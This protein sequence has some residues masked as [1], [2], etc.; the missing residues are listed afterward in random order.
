MPKKPARPCKVRMCPNLVHGRGQY[1][2]E[3]ADL[4]IRKDTRPSARLRGYDKEWYRIR[5]A[6][7]QA[8]PYCEEE[9]C[10]RLAEQ[11]D[12]KVPL[13]AGGTNDWANLRSLCTSCHSRKTAKYDGGF[14]NQKKLPWE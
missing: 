11:V 2:E 12:H 7:I 14:G 5:N 6:Y 1:C 9:G 4:G 3:H 13:R 10:G 8:H